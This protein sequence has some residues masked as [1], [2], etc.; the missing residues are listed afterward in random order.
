MDFVPTTCNLSS[1]SFHNIIWD[2][3]RTN[4]RLL[5]W[6]QT[7]IPASC[8]VWPQSSAAALLGPD[9]CLQFRCNCWWEDRKLSFPF[10]HTDFFPPQASGFK[11]TTFFF[12]F[13][14]TAASLSN[15][16]RA[17][18]TAVSLLCYFAVMKASEANESEFL[19]NWL[20]AQSAG[21]RGHSSF[22]FFFFK[23][24]LL[25]QCIT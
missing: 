17:S 20:L 5:W 16:S 2:L 19:W 23:Y 7:F 3:S 18:A 25:L 21:C 4:K 14:Q 9:M 10:H 1:G 13:G 11:L 6:L 12:F 8:P 15:L 24:C 22:F